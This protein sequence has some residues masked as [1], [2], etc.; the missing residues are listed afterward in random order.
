MLTWSRDRIK[1]VEVIRKGLNETNE[2]LQ[3]LG[4]N[5]GVQELKNDKDFN[6]ESI[7]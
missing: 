5:I 4:I 6:M 3:V 7:F 2:C 1:I